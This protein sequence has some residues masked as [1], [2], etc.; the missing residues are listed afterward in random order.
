PSTGAVHTAARLPGTGS[1]RDS[2]FDVL[3]G[4]RHRQVAGR[5]VWTIVRC[6]RS[7][8][9]LGVVLGGVP[10]RLRDHRGVVPA[11]AYRLP[12]PLAL[13]WLGVGPHRFAGC[14][15]KRRWTTGSPAAVGDLP[16]RHPVAV[17]GLAV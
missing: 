4:R 17:P 9:V 12:L 8:P 6:G 2:G 14:R 15:G 7:A 13:P 3:R 10:A 1:D 11:G 16:V 5:P